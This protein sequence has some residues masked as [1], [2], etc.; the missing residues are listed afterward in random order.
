MVAG[1]FESGPLVGISAA[2]ATADPRPLFIDPAVTPI[3]PAIKEHSPHS[4][5]REPGQ[6]PVA[7]SSQETQHV[8]GGG[9]DDGT[10][11][12]AARGGLRP[13][14]AEAAV[15]TPSQPVV[16]LSP[17]SSREEGSRFRRPATAGSSQEVHLSS[18]QPA[19]HGLKLLAHQGLRPTAASKLAIGRKSTVI[20]G[21]IGQIRL[22]TS[23][24]EVVNITR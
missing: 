9:E 15:A 5:L 17:T 11:P 23:R 19:Q 12:E 13:R 10:I 18:S 6:N 14:K 20:G 22:A 3:G 7:V 24:P 2:P 4:H 1:A 8:R 21:G 16:Q